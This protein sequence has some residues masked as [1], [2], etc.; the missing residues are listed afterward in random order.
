MPL[1]PAIVGPIAAVLALAVVA[2]WREHLAA[3]ARDRKR[4]DDMLD[5]ALGMAATSNEVAKA[6]LTKNQESP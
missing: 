1:D 6:A 3:D 4:G 5:R 2:L